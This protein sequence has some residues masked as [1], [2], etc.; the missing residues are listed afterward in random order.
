VGLALGI[1]AKDSVSGFGLI[2]VANMGLL[3]L[4]MLRAVDTR[5]ALELLVA[6]ALVVIAARDLFGLARFLFFG[7]DPANV[8]D[9]SS[10][11]PGAKL[12]FFEINDNLL[13]CIGAVYCGFRLLHDYDSLGRAQRWFFASV[14][15]LGVA[16]IALSLRRGAWG[17]LALA[18]ALTV[19]LAPKGKR[20]LVGIPML[21]VLAAGLAILVFKRLGVAYERAQVGWSALYYD[22]VGGAH[23]GQTSLRALELKLGWEAY[24][25]SPIFGKGAWGRF[26]AYSGFGETWHG[27]DGAFGYV[28]S[29]VIHILFKS[30]LIGFAVL[31]GLILSFVLFVKRAYP[32]LEPRERAVLVMGAAGALFMVP[33]FL[34]GTPFIQLRTTQIMGFCFA[35]PYVAYHVGRP[36]DKRTP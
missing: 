15:V 18:G 1:P 4:L 36:A 3:T 16:I 2:H 14:I 7:G 30:G 11:V 20:L 9:H 33:D 28:H 13:A 34:F 29:G 22:M 8:Y 21:A 32:L 12:T 27:G 31:C 5:K 19:L 25:E 17:G 26:E 10:Y 23:Y 6:S 24:V 35:L